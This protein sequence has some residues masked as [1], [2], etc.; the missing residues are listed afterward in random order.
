[1]QD[2]RI[3]LVGNNAEVYA[4]GKHLLT[5]HDSKGLVLALVRNLSLRDLWRMWRGN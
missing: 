1:M 4:D 3:Q 2:I 5:V